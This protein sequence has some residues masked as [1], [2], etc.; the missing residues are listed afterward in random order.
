MSFQEYE[1]KFVTIFFEKK[2]IF[3]NFNISENEI[4]NCKICF[5][6]IYIF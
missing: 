5:L 4:I 3:D 1:K 2:D 6:L